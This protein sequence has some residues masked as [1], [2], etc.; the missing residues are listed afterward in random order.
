MTD[1]NTET[2]YQ[3]YIRSKSQLEHPQEDGETWPDF[4]RR[5]HTIAL[6]VAA[7][8]QCHCTKAAINCGYCQSVEL[9]RDIARHAELRNG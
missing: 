3:K 8:S 7:H 4:A 6:W 9:V 2:E 5:G 1:A